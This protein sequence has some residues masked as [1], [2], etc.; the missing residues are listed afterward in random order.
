MFSKQ[1][2]GKHLDS[3]ENKT[4]SFKTWHKVYILPHGVKAKPSQRLE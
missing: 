1:S 4:V 3:R 2:Q